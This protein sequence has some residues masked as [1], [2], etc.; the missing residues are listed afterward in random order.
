MYT[1]RLGSGALNTKPV[2]CINHRFS[3]TSRTLHLS[4]HDCLRLSSIV[5]RGCALVTMT[6]SALGTLMAITRPMTMCDLKSF[7]KLSVCFHPFASS[8]HS[9]EFKRRVFW[10]GFESYAAVLL[11]DECS[12]HEA[13]L[14]R[15]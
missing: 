15:Q 2:S 11:Q 1:V 9:A 4:A 14:W 3:S 8:N 12:T 6:V 7:H 5:A 13:G 10:L